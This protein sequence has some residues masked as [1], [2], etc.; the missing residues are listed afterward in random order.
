MNIGWD[1]N[2]PVLIGDNVVI[3]WCHAFNTIISILVSLQLNTGKQVDALPSKKPGGWVTVNLLLMSRVTTWVSQLRNKQQS[4]LICSALMKKVLI[5][6]IFSM[7]L[8][9]LLSIW[10]AHFC[11]KIPVIV[12]WTANTTL[13]YLAVFFDGMCL[14]LSPRPRNI[15]IKLFLIA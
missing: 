13:P 9:S 4:K 5:S 10:Y 7:T 15:H 12:K 11:D 8:S 14:L 2:K 3:K 6:W 1:Q